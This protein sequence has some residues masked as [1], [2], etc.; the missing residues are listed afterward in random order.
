MVIYKEKQKQ[1][2]QATR[3]NPEVVNIWPNLD[4]FLFPY[5]ERFGFI[6]PIC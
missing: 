1:K 6:H 2:K 4:R 3:I 5:S